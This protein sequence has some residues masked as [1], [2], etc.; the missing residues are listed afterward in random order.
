MKSLVEDEARKLNELLQ[1]ALSCFEL[2]SHVPTVVKSDDYVHFDDLGINEVAKERIDQLYN[3]ENKLKLIENTSQLFDSKDISL[4]RRA[5]KSTLAVCEHLLPNKD[6]I[7][8]DRSADIS[9]PEF[10]LFINTFQKLCMQTKKYTNS[11]VQEI[12]EQAAF[13][14]DLT[15]K[16][17]LLE[18]TKR[19]LTI[20]LAS[21]I[22]RKEKIDNELNAEVMSLQSELNELTQVH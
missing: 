5:H 9:T 11:T 2:L 12:E 4:L 14:S 21:A 22:E 16:I 7:L 10:R 1:K 18:E 8:R 20:R 19:T 13:A 3:Y 17:R 15:D 6:T